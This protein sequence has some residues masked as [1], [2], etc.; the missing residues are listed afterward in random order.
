MVLFALMLFSLRNILSLAWF[1]ILI[2]SSTIYAFAY[3]QIGFSNPG[4]AEVPPHS[5][6]NSMLKVCEV[7]GAVRTVNTYHCPDCNVCIEGFDHHCPWIGKC[8]GANNLKSFYF[9]LVMVFG[10]VILCFVATISSGVSQA[11]RQ[12]GKAVVSG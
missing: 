10:N 8:V 1:C 9:F 4:F 6:Q 11:P 2:V 3:L 5:R 7:C 12:P